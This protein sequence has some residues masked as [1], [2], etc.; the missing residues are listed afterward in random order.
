M[1]TDEAATNGTPEDGRCPRSVH[2]NWVDV[3]TDRPLAG[4]PVA[5]VS[6]A[7]PLSDDTMRAIAREFNQSATTFILR[8]TLGDADRRFRSFTPAGEEIPGAGHHVLGA[9]IWLAAT[10]WLSSRRDTFVQQVDDL[11]TPVSIISRGV[12]R[13]GAGV[14]Q[15]EARFVR[16]VV[17]PDTAGPGTSR[18]SL[19]RALGLGAPEVVVAAEVVSTGV[20]QL[21]VRLP[22]AAAVDSCTPDDA[23]LHE[24]LSA[25]GAERCYAY[26]PQREAKHAVSRSADA[27]A[28]F[29][30]PTP[31]IAEDPASATA[32][33]PLA[34][35][36]VRDRLVE[37]GQTVH[38]EQGT[39]M[40]R[41]CTIDVRVDGT[42]VE[43]SAHGVV[44]AGGTL[45]LP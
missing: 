18:E 37:A 32:A 22:D 27:Y 35:L 13:A 34:A 12:G 39:A 7:D 42:D 21:L 25:V 29:F 43:I 36:L 9:W 2:F 6:D 41:P 11:L 3:F 23:A 16:T 44:S 45:W 15:G 26:A 4:N 1:M 24:A 17:Q 33:G 28:R 10:D 14:A 8:P 19:G 31:G 38:I 40:R 5:V 30:N 20:P